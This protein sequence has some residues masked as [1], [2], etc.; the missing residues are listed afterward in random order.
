VLIKTYHVIRLEKNYLSVA[1]F[2]FAID[3]RSSWLVAADRL[4]K[5]V[6]IELPPFVEPGGVDEVI[7]DSAKLA[8]ALAACFAAFS[9]K[10]FCFDADGGI[11]VAVRR[12]EGE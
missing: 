6:L 5:G 1:I 7:D 8:L 10:R 9:A 3:V 4:V 2:S 11:V 12:G